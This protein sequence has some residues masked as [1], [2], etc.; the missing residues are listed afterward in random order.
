MSDTVWIENL[1]KQFEIDAAKYTSEGYARVP[2]VP[3][4]ELR[5]GDIIP[6]TYDRTESGQRVP[7]GT[8]RRA[9]MIFTDSLYEITY[10]G[11]YTAEV[12]VHSWEFERSGVPTVSVWRMDA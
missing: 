6:N 1:R 2:G 7:A 9:R 4:T 3:L 8:V 5:Y 10:Q 11:G 12:R